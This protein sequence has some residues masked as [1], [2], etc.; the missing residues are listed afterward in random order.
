M[1]PTPKRRTNSTN[2][3]EREPVTIPEHLE[4]RCQ[5]LLKMVDDVAL[6]RRDLL[7]RYALLV[8]A[9]EEVSR[10]RKIA[11]SRTGNTLH[12]VVRAFGEKVNKRVDC[13]AESVQLLEDVCR[14][15]QQRGGAEYTATV[16]QQI[17][18]IKGALEAIRVRGRT[19][20]AISDAPARLQVP[21]LSPNARILMWWHENIETY[22]HRTSDMHLLS[23]C[24]KLSKS[25]DPEHF[26]RHVLN[27]MATKGG[28]KNLLDVVAFSA[29]PA[30]ALV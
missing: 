6:V 20:S 11:D 9:A 23:R 1:R 21:K 13:V 2:S 18:I 10:L 27:L 26:R 28:T 22:H 17:G 29:P 4:E 7:K 19:L 14:D 12:P 30:W 24:W 8:V 15:C 16:E 25:K 3:V 5:I